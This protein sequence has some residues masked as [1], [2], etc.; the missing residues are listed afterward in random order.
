[1]ILIIPHEFEMR[2]LAV[3]IAAALAA[4]APAAAGPVLD[5]VRAEKTLRCGGVE[6]PGLLEIEPSGKAHGLELDLCRAIAAVVLGPEGRLEFTR[7]DTQKAFDSARAGHEDVMF[8]TGRELVENGLTGRVAPGPAIFVETTSVMAPDEAPYRH[9]EDLAGLPICFSLAS[10]AQ[11]HLHAWF[12]AHKLSFTPMGFQEDVEM[13]DGYKARYCH[14][15][16]GETTTLAQTAHSPE[17]AAQK[18]RFLPETLAA[19]PILAATPMRDGEFSAV[20]AWTIDTLKRA[21]AADSQWVRGGFESMP[22]EAPALGLDKGWQKKLVAL[23]G[24]YGDLFDKNLG[25]K[26]ELKLDRGF[27]NAVT[28]KGA[29]TPPYVD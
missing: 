5:R 8:L 29:F 4:A 16:A 20:V 18:H 12:E 22:V 14:G 24:T 10:H 11:F 25:S 17:F 21:D 1:L 13:N 19:Y 3:L 26:S 7:Y 15:M 28:D 23:M 9:L 27:N 6:R 2:S